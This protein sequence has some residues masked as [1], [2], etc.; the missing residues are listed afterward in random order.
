MN[1]QKS[2]R[3][4][5]WSII[6]TQ[7]V[8]YSQAQPYFL[9]STKQKDKVG[10]GEHERELPEQRVRV[11][12]VTFSEISHLKE[13][14]TPAHEGGAGVG[15]IL[16]GIIM[17]QMGQ[18]Q[19]WVETVPA[20]LSQVAQG[21][22]FQ[23]SVSTSLTK[24]TT[25]FKNLFI[26]LFLFLAALGLRCCTHG[27]S[28]VAASRGYSS[29]WC[30][31][32][33]L[34][35]LLLLQSTG[36]RRTGFSSCGSPTLECRLS[37]CGSRAQLLCGMWHLP[38]PGLEPVSPALAGGFLATV[39]P[40]KSPRLLLLS[41]NAGDLNHAIYMHIEHKGLLSTPLSQH[42]KYRRST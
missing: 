7:F 3:R 17:G 30:A 19:L 23:E 33:S 6:H 9:I 36:S 27:L 29:L 35:W 26:C 41:R 8:L 13:Q 24:V 18:F 5:P 32:F 25:F 1:I 2:V 12:R 39:P 4:N 38:R 15:T 34:R 20:I 22:G 28:L 40:G 10:T 37:S 14:A 21:A 11:P 42:L 16:G 31:G